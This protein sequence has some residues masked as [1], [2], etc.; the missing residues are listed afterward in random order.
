LAESLIASFSYP[1]KH[2][3]RGPSPFDGGR[4]VSPPSA[5]LP[6]R[7]GSEQPHVPCVPPA[8]H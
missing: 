3:N 6:T 4:R 7:T 5:H 2:D 1:R 8:R